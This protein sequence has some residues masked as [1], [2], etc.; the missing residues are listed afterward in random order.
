MLSIS[1]DHSLNRLICFI[2]LVANTLC[3]SFPKSLI[4][5]LAN[6]VVV[7]KYSHIKLISVSAINIVT[8]AAP[9][10]HPSP[11]SLSAASIYFLSLERILHTS[12]PKDLGILIVISLGI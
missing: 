3:I 7:D 9:H 6:S 10:H 2:V 11:A 4:D 12:I 5:I 8:G 1:K